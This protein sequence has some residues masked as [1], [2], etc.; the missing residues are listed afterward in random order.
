MG[1]RGIGVVF[2][3]VQVG[4]LGII[5]QGNVYRIVRKLPNSMLILPPTYVSANAPDTPTPTA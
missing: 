3:N 2:W 5:L 1:I 4:C